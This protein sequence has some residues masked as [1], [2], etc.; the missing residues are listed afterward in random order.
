MLL[1]LFPPFH[2]LFNKL[3]DEGGTYY[4]IIWLIPMSITIAYASAMLFIRHHRIGVIISAILIALCGKIVYQ[5]EN[6][7]RASN[8]YH[9]P[10]NVI[11]ICDIIAPNEGE[12]VEAVV[13]PELVYYI[14][15]YNTDILLAYGREVV[16]PS[17]D[18]YNPMYVLM[19]DEEILDVDAMTE[20]MRERGCRYLIIENDHPHDKEYDDCGLY[21]TGSVGIYDIYEDAAYNPETLYEWINDEGVY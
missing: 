20:L 11:E 18:F 8:L 19:H 17:W 12:K 10:Q 21:L 16:E 7:S 2:F 1:F 13:E 15:Q 14:R 4:R 5:N 9:I 6:V 3:I